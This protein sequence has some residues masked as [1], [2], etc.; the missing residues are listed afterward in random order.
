MPARI[1]R[2]TKTEALVLRHRRLGD[3]DRIVTLLTPGRGKLDAV[4]RGVLRPRSK[5]AG[6]L[7][8]ATC[9]DVL[10]AHGRN[11]D[12]ITQAQTIESFRG[13]RGDLDRLSTA[14]Y[15][16]ELSD[17]LTVEQPHAPEGRSVYQLLHA[18]LLRLARGD[19]LQLVSRSFELA[20]LE[21][22]GF[23][24]EWR[25]CIA[26]GAAVEA[27]AVTWSSL[28]GGVV[29]AGC[30]PVHPEATAIDATVLKVLRAMQDGPYEEAA[31]IR[32][33]PELAAGLER[34]MHELMQTVAERE[35]KSQQFVREARRA[36]VAAGG[37]QR[38]RNTLVEQ[39]GEEPSPVHGSTGSP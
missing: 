33:T 10:L 18:S 15:L 12:I 21:A 14:I 32:L 4:A 1:P 28:G 19:G 30:R 20:L 8:P 24:P 29:C 23:R 17:R 35:L 34:V 25:S 6:H 5:L 3:A 27:D 16:T 38:T 13:L 31:R 7:Q 2:V 37:A 22:T 39:D 11:L 9:V 36:G 26:C